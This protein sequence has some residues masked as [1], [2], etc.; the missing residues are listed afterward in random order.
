MS[1]KAKIW[2]DRSVL[3]VI[4]NPS[5]KGYE[6]KIKSPEVTFLGVKDQPDFSDLYITIYPRSKIVELKSLKYYLYQFRDKIISYER[7]INVV[8]D[9]LMSAYE[10]DRLRIV[11]VFNPRGGISSR[12]TIDSDWNARGGDEKYKDWV[13][14]GDEW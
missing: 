2:S 1:D 10:P 6:V 9:D 3:K 8:Y 5:D 4:N 7:L 13:G 11:M 14:V 12:L